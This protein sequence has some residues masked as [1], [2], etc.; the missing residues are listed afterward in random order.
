MTL[1]AFLIAVLGFFVLSSAQLRAQ[2]PE[3]LQAGPREIESQAT[4]VQGRHLPPI[5]AHSVIDSGRSGQLLAA[6]RYGLF[7]SIDYL[8]QRVLRVAELSRLPGSQSYRP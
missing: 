1:K 8:D 6:S 4:V 2:Q 3:P 7:V 5:Q